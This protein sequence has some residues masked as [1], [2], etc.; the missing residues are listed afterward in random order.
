MA[1]DAGVLGVVCIRTGVSDDMAKDQYSPFTTGYMGCPALWVGPTAG[2]TVRVQA[3]LGATAT[4]TLEADKTKDCATET[5]WAVLR[6]GADTKEAVAINTHTDGPNVA[7]ENGGLGLLALAQKYARIPRS[8]RGRSLIFV[9]TTG[10]FQLPQF[11][12]GDGQSM[13]R[14]MADHPE[15]VDG[16]R[17]K[18]VAGLTLE[19]LGCTEWL[20]NATA[21]A[22][23]PSGR[24][25][26]AYCFTTTETLRRDYLASCRG[27]SNTRT[28]TA[29][30][31][32]YVG[33]GHDLHAAGIATASL[34]PAMSY[35]VAAPRDGAVDRLDPR[36][37]RGQIR[38]FSNLIQRLDRRTAAQ[39][40]TPVY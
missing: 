12:I 15:Y 27:T 38:S 4:L 10:H 31:V 29:L 11:A 39:I 30:P 23:G 37:M 33:E 5:I 40:G 19:H 28:I 36:Y 18:I 26:V 34:I 35:L 20:D 9:A 1:R 7:E 22:Y 25:D 3:L 8:Q 13:S 2:Q 16:G 17:K 14:W 32:I 24:K 21:N 6:G